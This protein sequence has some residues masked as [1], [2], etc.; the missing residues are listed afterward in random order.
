MTRSLGAKSK[1]QGATRTDARE[2]RPHEKSNAYGGTGI[3]VKLKH[4]QARDYS[5]THEAQALNGKRGH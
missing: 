1:R 4:G 2:S 3:Y 5:R